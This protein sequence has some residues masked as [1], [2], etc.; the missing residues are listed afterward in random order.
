MRDEP[1][2]P[3]ATS[4]AETRLERRHGVIDVVRGVSIVLVVLLHVQIRIPLQKTWL[5]QAAP[6]ELWHLLCRNG[7]AGVRMFFVVSGFLITTN[8]LRR[9]GS[10]HRIDARHFYRLRFARIAP[11]LVVLL[12]VLS[13]LHL[14][15]ANGYI[16]D[17]ER[18]SLGRALLAA[19]TF[20]LNWLEA[21]RNAYLPASWDV[22]W[23]LSVEEVFYLLFPLGA[24]LYRWRPA[25]HT[26]LLGLVLVGAW[27][28]CT[29][30]DAP[31]WQSKGYL[32]CADALALGCFTAIISHDKPIPQRIVQVL[33]WSGAA[34]T[35]AVLTYAHL[36]QLRYFTDRDL[37]LTPLALGTA[38]LMVAGARVTLGPNIAT[39]L[40]PLLACGRLSYEIYLTHAFVVLT[41]VAGFRA[42]GEP[43]AA[44]YPL[45]AAILTL[46]WA[47]GAGV[48]R[49]LSAPANRRLRGERSALSSAPSSAPRPKE[50]VASAPTH[51]PASE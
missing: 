1:G 22:L 32:P 48:E 27:V 4:V 19:S 26:L 5:F 17:T 9:W 30:V 8:S 18:W 23:S 42:L 6:A 31:M 39:C 3:V 33:L 12:A 13:L 49:W 34:L 38:A 29:L 25:G 7:N 20:H 10:L 43:P 45:L 16:I 46:S 44:V 14:A 50:R 36:P 51:A 11:T 24:I 28:R 15:G 21:S 40:R 37:H 41:A 35:L 2:V 47:L